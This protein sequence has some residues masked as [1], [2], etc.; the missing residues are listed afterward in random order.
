VTFN[1]P[2][3]R[4]ADTD[5]VDY[6]KGFDASD[7]G[8]QAHSRF[9]RI[10]AAAHQDLTKIASRWHETARAAIRGARKTSETDFF[11][12]QGHV[13]A[14]ADFIATLVVEAAVHHLDL[15]AGLDGKPSPTKSALSI[16][17]RT[18]DGLLRHAR[19]DAWDDIEYI[20]KATDREPLTDDDTIAL[21][22]AS[23]SLPVFS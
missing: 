1:S 17:T 2:A 9:V 5:F 12:T 15:V 3:P 6:W 21:G 14:N 4:P 22:E 23:H 19:P 10:S 20:L 18:L 16:T 7:D 13:L 11:T 8:S